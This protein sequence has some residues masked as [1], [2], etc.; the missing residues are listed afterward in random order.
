MSHAKHLF[1]RSD[2]M[3]RERQRLL[4]VRPSLLLHLLSLVSFYASSDLATFSLFESCCLTLSEGSWDAMSKA[5]G[6][7]LF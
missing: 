1:R 2:I 7:G 4:G 6:A 3:Q 5:L